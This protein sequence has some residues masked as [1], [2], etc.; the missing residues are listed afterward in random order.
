MRFAWGRGPKP[1]GLLFAFLVIRF[2]ITAQHVIR[3]GGVALS[4]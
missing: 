3:I 2:V 1:G 4:R